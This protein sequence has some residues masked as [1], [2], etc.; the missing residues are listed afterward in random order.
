MDVRRSQCLLPLTGNASLSCVSS[1]THLSL[2]DVTPNQR[3][4]RTDGTSHYF[5]HNQLLLLLRC[6]F[7]WFSYANQT[8]RHCRGV[9]WCGPVC[10]LQRPWLTPTARSPTLISQTCPRWTQK[11]SRRRSSHTDDRFVVDDWML[12][13]RSAGEK[14]I[15]FGGELAHKD[16]DRSGSSL[17]LQNA[18]QNIHCYIIK[19]S[20]CN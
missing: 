12:L 1:F 13:K 16:R 8:S 20:H 5:L 18:L 3:H 15:W 14:L 6:P 7:L 9:M 11:L 17:S 4:C 10:A 19:L 2:S